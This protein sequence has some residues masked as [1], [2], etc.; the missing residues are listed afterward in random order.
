M[1]KEIY[2]KDMSSMDINKE[3]SLPCWIKS[4]R[5]HGKITFL[6]LIDSTGTIQAVIDQGG[7]DNYDLI[8]C[9]LKIESAICVTGVLKKERNQIVI[10]VKHVNIISNDSLVLSPSPRSNFDIFNKK[11]INLMLSKRHLY[12]R[13]PKAIAILKFRDTLLHYIREWFHSNDFISVDAPILTPVSLYDDSSAMPINVHG[14]DVYLTQCVGYY[15]EASVYALERVYNIGPSFR[16]EESKSKRHLMEY[17]HIKAEVAWGDIEDIVKIVESIIEYVTRK[18]SNECQD[19]F[20][21]LNTTMCVDGI[22]SPFERITYRDAVKHLQGKGS[23]IKFGKGLSSKDEK[24][25]SN[26]INGAFWVTGIPRSIEPF[27]YVID[28]LDECIT[29]TADLISSNGYGE[30]L[31]VAEKIHDY[32]MLV[33]R[34]NEKNKM[35]D[36]RYDFIREVHQIG[37]VP[38]IAFGMGVER[39]VR[40]MLNIPHVRDAVPFPRIF[41]RNIKP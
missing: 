9:R 18:C 19:I 16:G 31:G 2:I 32:S 34:M 8:I 37:S 10:K 11:Y 1:L 27:P 14:E 39:L 20:S 33:E 41:R 4:I 25:L 23:D 36:E 7:V 24:V 29:V 6:D 5:T 28:S 12:I 26:Y 40:W 30:L 17:W 21:T 15:L 35:S 22:N 13:N 3:L 38:H